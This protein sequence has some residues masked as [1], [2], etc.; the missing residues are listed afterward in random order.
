M[1]PDSPLVGHDASA[2]FPDK[3]QMTL[4]REPD[5]LQKTVDSRREYDA[6]D[7]LGYA[8]IRDAES[9]DASLGQAWIRDAETIDA[10]VLGDDN[11]NDTEPVVPLRP[12]R[13]PPHVAHVNVYTFTLL[14]ILA[15]AGLVAWSL[16]RNWKRDANGQSVWV[17]GLW[18]SCILCVA[19]ELAQVFF[20]SLPDDMN[21]AMRINEITAL[22]FAHAHVTLV[23]TSL[24][25]FFQ[26]NV[27]T[28]WDAKWTRVD[29]VLTGLSFLAL[30]AMLNSGADAADMATLIFWSVLVQLLVATV[31]LVFMGYRFW[32]VPTDPKWKLLMECMATVWMCLAFW[33]VCFLCIPVG[34]RTVWVVQSWRFAVGLVVT[35]P[36]VFVFTANVW[37]PLSDLPYNTVEESQPPKLHTIEDQHV[38]GDAD[39][40]SDEFGNF[41]SSPLK[42]MTIGSST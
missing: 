15:A 25:R 16:R 28:K 39:D 30:T 14:T 21:H 29:A 33:D 24:G 22:W 35:L 11:T 12:A 36:L 31:A 32:Q 5:Q 37:R 18:L 19:I 3:K 8:W 7:P 40:E 42:A 17:L 9:M 20:A 4:P 2:V 26:G 10:F 6:Q 1:D 13:P 27:L 34:T 41:A 38:N 23:L